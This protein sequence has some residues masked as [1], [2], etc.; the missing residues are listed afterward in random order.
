MI[1]P[2]VN[3]RGIRRRQLLGVSP[4][5]AFLLLIFSLC[6]VRGLDS[7]ASAKGLRVLF[8]GNSLT[9]YNHL[10]SIIEALA[11]AS[12]QKRFQFRMIAFPNFSLEDHWQQGE[13]LRSIR[14]GGWDAVVLQQGPSASSEGREVLL[15]Y[16]RRFSEEIH[17]VGAKPAL[18]MVW[19]ATARS[20]DFDGVAES[21]RRAATISKGLLFP[22]GEAWRAALRRDPKLELYSPDGLHPTAAGSYLAALVIYQQLYERSPIG[23]P[24]R[25]DVR[26]GNDLELTAE[27]SRVMQ[28]A[29]VEANQKSVPR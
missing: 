29:A 8:V 20:Q 16:A 10:P 9:Y 11:D 2:E 21:Y 13:A 19:P 25:L 3:R 4:A 12:G 24:F 5:L 28:E 26:S 7:G 15:E 27:Q 6:S 17:R 18:Y 23:L 22:V 14:Q 1:K